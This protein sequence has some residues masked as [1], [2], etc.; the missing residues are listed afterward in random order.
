[1]TSKNQQIS[2]ALEEKNILLREIHHRVK[3]NLQVIS[4]LLKLQSQYIEDEGAVKAIAEGRNRVHSMAL[5]HQ[6]LYKEDNLTGVNM[7]EYFTNLIEGLFDAYKITEI[8]LV[9]EIENLTLDIDT[10]IPLGLIANELVSNA[11]KHAFYNVE[12]GILI[13]KLWEKD[14]QLLFNVRDNGKGYNENLVADGKK[15]FGQ[16]LIKSLSDKL[17][18]DVQVTTTTGT[19]VTL[20]IKDYKKVG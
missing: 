5:L 8:K 17:E 4:S 9:T 11:L 12:N 1:L 10:V 6:N 2:K 13:V 15:S 20:S 3:N 16:K 7:K 18:A 14:G 19:D